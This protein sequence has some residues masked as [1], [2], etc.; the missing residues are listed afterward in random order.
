MITN[1]K[2]T[3]TNLN[4]GLILKYDDTGYNQDNYKP[5]DNEDKVNG[6]VID[7]D[8]EHINA[9]LKKEEMLSITRMFINKEVYQKIIYIFFYYL[10]DL[11]YTNILLLFFHLFLNYFIIGTSLMQIIIILLFTEEAKIKYYGISVA[12]I[13]LSQFFA[14]FLFFFSFSFF[15]LFLTFFFFFLAFFFYF[16]FRF[17][18]TIIN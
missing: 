7:Y 8:N 4:L 16:W 6:Y 15:F 11:N 10:N 14:F 9:L 12:L 18:S 5:I 2:Y 3:I 17:H 13:Y 1:E